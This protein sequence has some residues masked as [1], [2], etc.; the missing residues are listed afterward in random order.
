MSRSLPKRSNPLI[1]ADA[2]PAYE[3]LVEQRRL[4]RTNLSIKP[5]VVGTCSATKP[6]NL[7]V[8]EY[9]F[10]RAPLPE[11]LKG[12]GIF[13][14]NTFGQ[15]P[16][17]YF[18]MRRSKDGFISAT[19]MFKTAFPWAKAEEEKNEREYL[20]SR[21][22]V[23]QEENAGNIWISP[24]IA[25]E[26]ANEYKIYDWVRALLDPVEIMPLLST[27]NR[28]ILITPPP[29][30]ELPM[31]EPKSL[32]KTLEITALMKATKITP[33]PAKTDEIGVKANQEEDTL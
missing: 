1:L 2:A 13:S 6:E 10:L 14:P 29:K 17:T 32:Q 15:Y 11:D 12:S 26:L 21:E 31:D 7:G 30:F 28:N 8:F 33:L 5:E 4:G 19:G 3:D 22:Y 27:W 20:K 9:A 16:G 24:V 25:L 23:S 18:L